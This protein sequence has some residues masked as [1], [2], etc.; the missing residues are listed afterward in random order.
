L[1][2]STRNDRRAVMRNWRVDPQIEPIPFDLSFLQVWMLSTALILC[3]PKATKDFPCCLFHLERSRNV[4]TCKLRQ[5]IKRHPLS[6]GDHAL[7]ESMIHG[8]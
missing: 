3:L 7:Q 1:F 4:I 5:A 2:L 8:A 6:D